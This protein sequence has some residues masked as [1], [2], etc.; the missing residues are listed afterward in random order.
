MFIY[1]LREKDIH[2]V[3]NVVKCVT[4]IILYSERKI[5]FIAEINLK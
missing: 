2:S 3:I 4:L 1:V 5:G